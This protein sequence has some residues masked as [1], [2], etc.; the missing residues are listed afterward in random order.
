MNE[1]YKILIVEDEFAIALNLKTI[2]ISANYT[3]VGIA[4][5]F[6]KCVKLCKDDR[7]DLILM[8]IQIK[9][10]YDG[11]ESASL[12]KDMFDIPV[13]F[14]TAFGQDVF[15]ERAKKLGPEAY[16]TKPFNTIELLRT[17]AIA[18]EKK[19]LESKQN[20][21]NLVLNSGDGWVKVNLNDI[22][23]IMSD[24][25]YCTLFF[26][27][28]KPLLIN[29]T[30]KAIENKLPKL[31]FFRCHQS[32]LISMK[33]IKKIERDDSHFAIMTNNSKI[34][35]ARVKRSIMLEKFKQY[36]T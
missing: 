13:L 26:D 11:I 19:T 36:I 7:P 23:Y 2:L 12:I 33:K 18:C 22:I 31:D 9:G 25:N 16:I 20:I 27:E 29:I 1:L 24:N 32:Y 15:F 35:I 28:E 4:D 14:I 8:D 6:K 17:I 30:L 10:A 21:N 5:S 34:P 3:V